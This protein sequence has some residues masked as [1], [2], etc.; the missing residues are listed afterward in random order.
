MVL[1]RVRTVRAL[2]RLGGTVLIAVVVLTSV[3]ALP[4]AAAPATIPHHA[5][6][7]VATSSAG[8]AAL[9]A[10]R[11]A[12]GWGAIPDS[13]NPTLSSASAG[14]VVRTVFPGFNTSLDG[15]FTSS[16]SA[17]QVGTPTYVP[18]TN[19]L[20]FPQRSVPVPGYPVPT[21]AP[22]AVFNLSTGGFDQFVT[23]LSNASALLYD[24]GNGNVYATLP[25]SN[26]VAAVNPRTGALA[27]R[28]IPVG[29]APDALAVNPTAAQLYVANS[30][31]SNVTVINT[32]DNTVSF[33]SFTVGSDPIS[34]AFDPLDNL[35][36]VAN[37]GNAFLSVINLTHMV[38]QNPNITLVNGPAAG[39]AF[40]RQSD[41][42]LATTPSNLNVTLIDAR[43]Q[44]PLSAI[45]HVGKGMVAVTTS[46]N[47]TEFVLGNASGSDVVILNST[48]GSQVGT[49]ITVEA[50][51]T[52]LLPDPQSGNVYCWTSSARVLES[53]NLSSKIGQP[54]TFTTSP[55]L[56]SVS[57][58]PAQSRVFVSSANSSLI[59]D[60]NSTRLDQTSPVIQANAVPLSTVTDPANDRLYVGTSTGLDVYNA[61]TDKLNAT[62][63][64]L[65]GNCTQ[66]V[67]DQPDNLLW[68]ANNL[69]VDA[70][71]LKTLQV[72]NPT[73]LLV[74]VGST[75]GIAFDPSDS[76]IFV[77]VSPSTVEVLSSSGES[78]PGP[79]IGVGANVTSLA[80][81]PSDNQVYAAGDAVTL[82][83]GTS[84]T[85]D[86]GPVLLGGPHKVL[87]AV[88]EP[89]REDIYIASVGLLPGKQ[90][91]VSVLDGSSV[92]ASE[93]SSVEIPVGEAPDAFGIVTSR[94]NAVPGSAMVWVA[95]ALSG[96]V[97][98]ISSPPQITEFVASPSPI[99]LGYPS[100][101]A[102]SYLGGAGPSTV[103]FYGLPPG[104][105]SSD[106]TQLNCT[107]SSAGVYMLAVN[108]TDSFGLSANVT[109]T[110]TVEGSLSVLLKS[111]L[112]TFPDTDVGVP[113]VLTP[114]VSGGLSPYSYL[115][116][117]GDGSTATGPTASHPY[118]HPGVF[119]LTTE[120]RD[121]T[122]ATNESSAVV[123]VNPSP[124]VGLGLTPGN[125]TDVAIPLSLNA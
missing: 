97:S 54:A 33:P 11:S 67:L 111:T 113:L 23:N 43:L 98:V 112:A 119:L 92:S 117:F 94:N 74:P 71:S 85:V 18:S 115:W 13:A 66:L 12:S 60:L 88:Y 91:M 55:E 120:V 45:L 31:S 106:E 24:P 16:V 78:P 76:E 118:S 29:S 93:A 3:F 32:A 123:T 59:Y 72:L 36:F 101:V 99:D 14:S 109:A 2:W 84:H 41:R 96:T 124:S 52:E 15:S 25:A 61:S 125:V 86:G 77:L 80:Y 49:D 1:G 75:Q 37:A 102:V 107:P 50:H 48:D 35:V 105:T 56:L 82:V 103:T 87:G 58:S 17:W 63:S 47:G 21:I 104:C 40:S 116:S 8:V 42:L 110:L 5:T 10:A 114:T 51:P 89:S 9:Q 69:A 7:S 90:G 100:S 20:W 73:G 108:V 62:A 19:T 34:L 26:S 44:S 22:V 46:T 27:D 64:A 57:S 79:E 65:T 81:D 68:L 95:N 70:V 83:N 121:S 30:G 39:L 38:V 4:A 122:G 28:G 6:S 53:V